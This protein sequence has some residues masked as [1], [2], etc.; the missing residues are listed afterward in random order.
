MV[1]IRE[2]KRKSFP[3]GNALRASSGLEFIHSNLCGLMNIESIRGNRHMSHVC[4]LKHKSKAFENL[5]KF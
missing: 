1:H 4:F 5:R 3:I 2:T